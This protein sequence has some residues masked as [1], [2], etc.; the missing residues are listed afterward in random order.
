M[1]LEAGSDLNAT[2]HLGNSPLHLAAQEKC[3]E[4]LRDISRGFE[5]VAIPC[6]NMVD[7]ESYPRDFLY[8]TGN[9][10]SGSMLLPTKAWDQS[11]GGQLRLDTTGTAPEM[12]S[13]YECSMLCACSRS[14]PNRVVQ[15][16]LRT[17]LQ[18]YRTAGKGWGVRTVQDVPRGTFLCQYFGELIS[19]TEAAHRE[20]DTY[21]FVVDMQNGQQ[22][23][24]DGRYYGNVGRFLNHSCQPNLVALQVALGYEIPGIAFFS[25]RAIPAGEELG[26]DYGDQFWEVKSW[27]CTCLCG[28]P[29]CRR[30]ARSPA[31]LPS[32]AAGDPG[33]GPSSSCPPRPPLRGFALKTKR[34]SPPK[35]VTRSRLARSP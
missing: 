19:N 14:C 1:L 12:G 26:F 15:R 32:P 23:C 20:E 25:T 2:N 35:R 11:Q 30:L 24:L 7:Q 9:I 16:G 3:H 34:S 5:Q 8:I 29:G 31:R 22:C 18:L 6:L 28:S 33:P 21:Y 4:C 27:N 10:M 13:I 17:Q